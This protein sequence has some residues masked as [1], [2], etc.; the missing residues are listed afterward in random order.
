MR[1]TIMVVTLLGTLALCGWTIAQSPATPPGEPARSERP[2]PTLEDIAALE[3]ERDRLVGQQIEARARAARVEADLEEARRR[4]EQGRVERKGLRAATGARTRELAVA[5]VKPADPKVGPETAVYAVIVTEPS[6]KPEEVFI[7][8]TLESLRQVLAWAKR[9]AA[10]DWRVV[11]RPSGNS[12][13]AQAHQH[14]LGAAQ[15]AGFEGV[16]YAADP[17]QSAAA[18]A[19]ERLGW[20][21]P[22]WKFQD[23]KARK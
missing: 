18:A 5:A 11:V 8:A 12:S 1:R 7:C 10:T 22:S 23:G 13:E 21:Y 4:Y 14:A 9:D 15:A 6:G 16:K 2:V 17:D 20:N 3:A 19:L